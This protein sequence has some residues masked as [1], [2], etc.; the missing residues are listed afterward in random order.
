M[1]LLEARARRLEPPMGAVLAAQRPRLC[2]LR[3]LRLPH[4]RSVCLRCVGAGETKTDTIL[5]FGAARLLSARLSTDVALVAVA[6]QQ[7]ATALMRCKIGPKA[8]L[9]SCASSS[10]R[11][12]AAFERCGGLPLGPWP[13]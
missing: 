9:A 5:I 11:L 13:I 2:D 8:Q 10:R 7:Q 3:L 12:V 4:G 1:S 6:A